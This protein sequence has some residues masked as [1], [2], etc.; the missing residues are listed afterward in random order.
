MTRTILA[1]GLVAAL[2]GC[3]KGAA[4]YNEG[5]KQFQAKN[6]DSAK[7]LFEKAIAANPD[8]TEA[9]YNLGLTKLNLAFKAAGEEKKEDAIK[10]FK[11][12][13]E[14]LKKSLSLMTQGKFVAYSEQ[15]EKDRLKKQ[16]EDMIAK[17]EVD[18]AVGDDILFVRLKNTK[19]E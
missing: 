17:C 9:W 16:C 19:I 13:A 10:L 14:D 3:I 4:D 11:A 6:Y 5:V 1:L 15:A 18:L 8:F 12:G 2:S 7:P